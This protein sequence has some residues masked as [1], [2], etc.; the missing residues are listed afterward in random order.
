M[1][2]FFHIFCISHKNIN[3]L[4]IKPS[5]M[6]YHQNFSAVFGNTPMYLAI[7]S[8]DSERIYQYRT[9]KLYF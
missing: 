9:L 4:L 7:I 3:E 1:L 8:G 6:M 2:F 5:T